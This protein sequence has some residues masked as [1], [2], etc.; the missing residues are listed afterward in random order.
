MA[1]LQAHVNWNTCKYKQLYVCHRHR[2]LPSHVDNNY[3]TYKARQSVTQPLDAYSFV[4]FLYT[5]HC[6]VRVNNAILSRYPCIVRLQP[7]VVVFTL[8]NG[9]SSKM[10][11]GVRSFGIL[12]CDTVSWLTSC[13]LL[14]VAISTVSILK[15]IPLFRSFLQISLSSVNNIYPS[16]LWPIIVVIFTCKYDIQLYED[17]Y[18]DN[19]CSSVFVCSVI[20]LFWFDLYYLLFYYVCLVNKDFQ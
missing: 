7:F 8:Y 20:V 9:K 1:C 3:S 16:K 4:R 2:L 10:C 13:V 11:Q 17:M 19:K 18:W 6:S 15:E 12:L 14:V 5:Q